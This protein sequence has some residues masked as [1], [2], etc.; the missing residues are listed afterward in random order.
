MSQ[1]FVSRVTL[2][3][4]VR[5]LV[6]TQSL[7]ARVR[8]RFL[9]CRRFNPTRS[10]ENFL[11]WDIRVAGDPVL[12]RRG[13]ALPFMDVR[14]PDRQVRTRSGVM[15]R[16]ESLSVQPFG[17]AAQRGVVLLPRCNGIIVNHA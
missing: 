8:L 17:P 12:G 6:I 14:E 11:R 1:T 13:A 4:L 2:G 5:L 16:A 3:A 10:S 15:Q 9:C 7:P